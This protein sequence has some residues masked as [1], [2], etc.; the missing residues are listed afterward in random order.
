[1]VSR[2]YPMNVLTD[3]GIRTDEITGEMI[4]RM[5]KMVRSGIFST[6]MY[7]I[8]V[9]HYIEGLSVSEIAGLYDKTKNQVERTLKRIRK[10]L[11]RNRITIE[12]D[13]PAETGYWLPV[14]E[15]RYPS[16]SSCGDELID[17]DEVY[18]INQ[19]EISV[20]AYVS[21][22]RAGINTI[23]D[24]EKIGIEGLRSVKGLKERDLRNIEEEVRKRFVA[25]L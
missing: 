24:I 2:E 17:L 4:R 15:A 20:R 25:D 7:R 23:M 9:K 21:L 11:G 14:P 5:R 3:M 16:E 1:M 22:K 6:D 10:I 13:F 12:T 18:N 19:L 8:Y